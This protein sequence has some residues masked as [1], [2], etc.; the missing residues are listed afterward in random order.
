MASGTSIA[1]STSSVAESTGQPAAST[2]VVGTQAS[3]PSAPGTAGS[4]EQPPVITAAPVTSAPGVVVTAALPNCTPA[5]LKTLSAGKLTFATGDSLAAPWFVGADPADGQG[6]ESAVAAAVA[7]ELDYAPTAVLWTSVDRA[8]AAAG[9]ESGFDVALDQFAVPDT[10]SRAVDYSTGYFGISD[11]VVAKTDT[12]AAAVSSLAGLKNLRVA[13]VSGSTGASAAKA[14]FASTPRSSPTTAGA[15][16]AVQSGAVDV[17]V[18]PTPAAVTAKS[19]T[20]VGQLSDPTE[21]PQQFGMILAKDSALTSC[22][23]AA[24]DQLRVT[25][26]LT[27]LL[28][29]WIPAA[30]KPLS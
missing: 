5:T 17:A 4:G 29:R 27:A 3:I 10:T 21:Q 26:Q 1:E 18:V 7:K 20:V 15:L 22:V 11:S 25:G 24:I 13:T 6:Y 12:P 16:A 28:Q 8:K 19:V 14:Q 30:N 23:S 2:A 9:Q